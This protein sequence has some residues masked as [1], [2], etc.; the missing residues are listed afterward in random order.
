MDDWID[1]LMDCCKSRRYD[2]NSKVKISKMPISRFYLK[3]CIFA[4]S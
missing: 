4:F 1:G 3:A 2:Q